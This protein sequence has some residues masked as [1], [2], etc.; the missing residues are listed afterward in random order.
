[1]AMAPRD[2]HP[3]QREVWKLAA[4]QYGAVTRTQLVELG[5]S[6]EAI[7]HR[8]ARGRLHPVWGGVYALGRPELTPRGRWLAATLACGREAWLSHTCAGALWGITPE[9]NDALHVSVPQHIRPRRAGIVIHRRSAL[10][11]DDV[12]RHHRIPVTSPAL[13]IIDLAARLR[14]DRL[15]R[16][17]N[18]ADRRDL[19]HPEALRRALDGIASRPGVR[20]LR[21]T[22]DH[23]TFVV[24]E[25]EL[26]RRFLPIASQLGLPRPRTG[27][28]VNGF[29]VDFYW[30][31]LGLVV[32]TDGLRYHRTP[33]Q[34]ARDRLRDQV[35]AAAG[36]TTLRFTHAQVVRDANHVCA[37]LGKVAR[38]L[39]GRPPPRA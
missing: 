12:T 24:T 10:G 11:P 23:P 17:I 14:P 6:S 7:R 20:A 4:E 37:T 35:H 31:E 15:E 26:E 3:M 34:Q 5:F 32:E 16:A 19:I 38:R 29:R 22:L 30:P 2:V 25:S 1:M 13:T 9:T 28:V 27:E 39:S 8:I 21:R 33:A 18:E 36:L